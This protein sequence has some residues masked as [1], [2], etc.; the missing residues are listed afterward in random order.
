MNG[1][2]SAVQMVIMLVK[3]GVPIENIAIAATLDDGQMQQVL[4]GLG[5]M[6]MGEDQ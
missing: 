3:S 5:S 6:E 1:K 4:D 2:I